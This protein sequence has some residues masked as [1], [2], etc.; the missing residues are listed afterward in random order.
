[1]PRNSG[2]DQQ[3]QN[4]AN[5]WSNKISPCA[6]RRCH[7]NSSSTFLRRQRVLQTMA[8]MQRANSTASAPASSTGFT[9]NMLSSHGHGLCVGGTTA[10]LH[11]MSGARL[12]SA[13][14]TRSPPNARLKLQFVRYGTMW[15]LTEPAYPSRHHCEKSSAGAFCVRSLA[16]SVP[17]SAWWELRSSP[18]GA[19]ASHPRKCGWQSA[20]RSQ[21]RVHAARTTVSPSTN[22]TVCSHPRISGRRRLLP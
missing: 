12:P 2:T 9:P 6:P 13:T 21:V 8:A 10:E 3:L 7:R 16:A 20:M 19:E 5:V 22:T 4:S 18:P 17:T 1:M 11:T 14:P 15:K